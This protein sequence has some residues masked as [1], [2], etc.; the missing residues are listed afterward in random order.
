LLISSLGIAVTETPIWLDHIEIA[1]YRG[2]S[3]PVR[4]PLAR[5]DRTKAGSGLTLL[6]GAQGSGKSTVLETVRFL[7]RTDQPPMLA[8][9]RRNASQAGRVNITYTSTSGAQIALGTGRSG[10]GRFAWA[11]SATWDVAWNRIF[12]VPAH[13]RLGPGFQDIPPQEN[14]RDQYIQSTAHGDFRSNQPDQFGFRLVAADANM[15]KFNNLFSRI[16]Q[17]PNWHLDRE[18]QRG[19]YLRLYSNGSPFDTEGIAD[20]TASLFQIVDALYD[21]RKGDIIGVDEIDRSLHPAVRRR[22]L[23]VL[24]ALSHDRQI[25]VTTHDPLCIDWDV[26]LGGAGVV[27]FVCDPGAIRVGFIT[28]DT[29]ALLRPMLSDFCN[30]HVLGPASNEIFF[31]DDGIWLFEGQEDVQLYPRA[32]EQ[33]NASAEGTVFGWGVG[34]ADNMSR[35]ATLLRD[36]GFRRVV[37]VVDRNKQ[38]GLHALS[39]AFPQYLFVS[40]PA[41]D[42]RTKDATD[43]RPTVDGLLDRQFK[44]RPEYVA[45]LQRLLDGANHY[46]RTGDK[47]LGRAQ[48]AGGIS[49]Y[50][51]VTPPPSV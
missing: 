11:G 4:I 9:N 17:P 28:D 20:G 24:V 12:T 2:F 46:M 26:V 14:S 37:G 45:E 15:E 47:S 7:Q 44:L 36:L 41:D 49:A 3:A 22:L 13:R 5:P 43:A 25:V 16:D 39:T 48:V 40:N 10:G 31:L 51:T 1:G 38:S 8:G 33:L 30:P 32:F 42:I 21:S 23:K 18:Q 27:R 6:V 35:I 34:G 29:R 19:A 50:G